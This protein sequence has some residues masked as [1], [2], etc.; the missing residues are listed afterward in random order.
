MNAKTNNM[1]PYAGLLVISL[2]FIGVTMAYADLDSLRIKFG[3]G[4][5]P[6]SRGTCTIKVTASGTDLANESGLLQRAS[7]RNGR[8]RNVS[9]RSRS[10][11]DNGRATIR[12]QN[13]QGCYRFV[14]SGIRSNVICEG[15]NSSNGSSS[16]S[17]SSSSNSNSSSSSSSGSSSSGSSSSDDRGG[18]GGG[19]HGGRDDD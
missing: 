7:S 3:G 2:T 10:L 13:N 15:S 8:Y 17:N 4:C 12:F 14:A 16:S 9:N 19:G 1:T 11:D 6:T 5:A 18:H